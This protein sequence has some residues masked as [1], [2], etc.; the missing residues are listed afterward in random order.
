MMD[1]QKSRKLVPSSLERKN[2]VSRKNDNDGHSLSSALSSYVLALRLFT[3]RTD[4]ATLTSFPISTFPYLD[5]PHKGAIQPV[6]IA[7]L[8]VLLPNY[9]TD[10]NQNVS[11]VKHNRSNNACAL[12]HQFAQCELV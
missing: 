5:M 3:R 4:S 1:E 7:S 2:V 9:P 8:P 11:H 6:V 10:I 12:L